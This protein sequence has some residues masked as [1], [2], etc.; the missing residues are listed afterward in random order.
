MAKY[1]LRIHTPDQFGEIDW[2]EP[3]LLIGPFDDV[4]DGQAKARNFRLTRKD[5]FPLEDGRLIPTGD[6][7]DDWTNRGWYFGIH[8]LIPA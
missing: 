6:Q 5:D 1:V 8:K 7:N 4:I 3:P 2:C